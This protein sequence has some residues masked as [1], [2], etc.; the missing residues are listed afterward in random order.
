VSRRPIARGADTL[1]AWAKRIEDEINTELARLL[2]RESTVPVIEAM[3][4]EGWEYLSTSTLGGSR[5]IRL[6][7]YAQPR[8][9]R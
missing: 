8:A 9:E 7:H 6:T 1:D 4:P 5:Q 2:P 3:L